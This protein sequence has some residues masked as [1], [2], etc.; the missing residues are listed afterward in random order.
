M[1]RINT[2][3][4]GAAL[5]L[6]AGCASNPPPVSTG[7]IDEAQQR[8]EEAERA[9]A[10][11]YANRELNLAR[12]KVMQALE[13]QREGDFERAALLAEHAELDAAYATARANNAS[14]QAAVDELRASLA[15]LESELQRQ[16]SL[17]ASA[18]GN[19]DRGL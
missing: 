7:S 12:D 13:A 17:P 6:L 10:Q 1:S 2:L 4:G 9:E 3:A 19:R 11:R 14:V 18:P 15:T 16:E 8:I 5:V